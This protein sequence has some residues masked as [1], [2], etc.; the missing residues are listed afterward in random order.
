MSNKD[1]LLVSEEEALNTMAL[2]DHL[3]NSE[4]DSQLIKK[5]IVLGENKK[6]IEP[7]PSTLNRPVFF[8]SKLEDLND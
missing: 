6:N 4:T 1:F 5:F 7:S 8:V 2:I 3:K